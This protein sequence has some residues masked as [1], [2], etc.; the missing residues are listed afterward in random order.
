MQY[1]PPRVIDLTMLPEVQ[2]FVL[3]ISENRTSRRLFLP[4]AQVRDHSFNSSFLQAANL[5]GNARTIWV[6]A[7][8]AADSIPSESILFSA[9]GNVQS[10]CVHVS[11][12][13]CVQF[14]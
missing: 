7:E 9:T 6:V 12:S 10:L 2:G 8:T 3:I 13:A 14:K 4:G 1:I 5:T 11:D